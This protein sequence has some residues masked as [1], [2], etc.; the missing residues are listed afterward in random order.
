ML[1]YSVADGVVVITLRNPPVNAFGM[2]LRG[3]VLSAL[4]RAR[5]DETVSAIIITGNEKVFCGGADMRQFN[6][7][8]YWAFPRTIDVAERMD[9]LPKLLVAAIA[10]AALGGGLELALACHYRI[11]APSARLA[12]SE[13][14]LGLLPGGG[15][16]LRLP[17]LI[18]AEAAIEMMVTGEPAD[19][20][21]ALDWG[22]VDEIA[23]GDLRGAAIAY[24]H[25]LIAERAPLR[26]A[27][28]LALDAASARA[29]LERARANL[30]GDE[31][32]RLA[33]NTILDVM[34]AGML[35]PAGQVRKRIDQAT[36][37]LMESAA[38]RA[39]IEAFFAERAARKAARDNA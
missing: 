17:R 10:G 15:G 5:A 39:L 14:K 11:A 27:A 7:P 30:P 8:K 22:L 32:R 1:D 34:E 35:L 31:A 6:T 25:R 13:V 29:A 16:T 4:E 20:A 37:D 38:A 21:R 24:A 28:E 18:G 3:A 23:R 12:L 9:Q 19:A 33:R 26:K 36:R 2:E